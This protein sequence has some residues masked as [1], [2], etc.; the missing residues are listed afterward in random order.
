M[1]LPA[2]AKPPAKTA[3]RGAARGARR[4]RRGA[5][6]MEYLVVATFILIAL[7]YGVQHL[8]FVAG[9]TMQH[10]ADATNFMNATGP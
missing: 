8:G 5:T 7:I 6:A 9:N 1:L 3:R 2:L 4:R 10:D